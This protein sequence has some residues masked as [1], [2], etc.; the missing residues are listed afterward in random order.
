MSVT[1]EPRSLS[2]LDAQVREVMARYGVPGLA[3]GLRRGGQV[4]LRG[5][6]VTSLETSQPV[7]PDTLFQ[8][9]SITKVYTAALIMRLVAEGVLDLDTP[10]S[11][12]LPELR[13]RDAE[14]QQTITLRHLLSHTSGLFGDRFDDYGLGDDALAKAIADFHTLEQLTRPGELWTYCNSGFYLAGRVIEQVLETGYEAAMRERLFAPLGLERTFFFAHEA[15]VYPVA[16]GHKATEPGATAHEVVRAYPLPRCVNAAGSI[17]QPVGDL[18]RFAALH[19]DAGLVDGERL[20]A[21]ELV[22]AMQ[23]PQTE[24][25][26]FADYYGLGWHLRDVGGY[27]LV[28]HGGTTNGFQADLNLIPAEDFAL[29]LLTNSSRGHAANRELLH[30]VL[31]REFGIRPREPERVALAADEVAHFTGE[32]RQPH[33]RATVRAGDGA[34]VLDL[35]SVSPLSGDETTLPAIRLEPLGGNR[36]LVANGDAQ[37]SR[38]E[39]IP[40]DAGQGEHPRFLRFG[41]RL[42]SYHGPVSGD[43]PSA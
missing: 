35:V 30:W 43:G 9:G 18:L 42:A 6:G 5:Y 10:V 29:A 41:G 15:I 23:Q 2:G 3:L 7:T 17:I 1:S 13:L 14:A 22:A 21:P 19:L 31:E 26:N 4:E 32:Y 16:V 24:A 33:A 37:G 39:F 20:L 27:R 12:Y 25:G 40:D 28:G 8:I 38:A 11:R 34:L 36:F